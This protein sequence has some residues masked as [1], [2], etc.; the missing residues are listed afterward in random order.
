MPAAVE[1]GVVLA[2]ADQ[3]VLERLG[4]MCE[5]SFLSGA[6]LKRSVPAT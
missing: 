4:A 5:Y 1:R 6:S 3:R 2:L